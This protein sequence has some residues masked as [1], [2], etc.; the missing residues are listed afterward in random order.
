MQ[1]GGGAFVL[2]S[3]CEKGRGAGFHE[4][5]RV[6]ELRGGACVCNWGVHICK[7]YAAGRRDGGGKALLIISRTPSTKL[8]NL[9][10]KEKGARNENKTQR[11]PTQT[12]LN[13]RRHW[14][15]D[16]LR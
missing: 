15:R 5:E 11:G 12:A 9:D 16:P 3:V 7:G 14:C 8:E 10:T 4:K 13:T 2:A 1:E 6:H